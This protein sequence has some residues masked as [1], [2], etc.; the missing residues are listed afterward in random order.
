MHL[1][2]SDGVFTV[3]VDLAPGDYQYKYVVD[4]VWKENPNQVITL[5]SRVSY[6]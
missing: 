5:I 1:H 4:D 3:N 6:G 2:I